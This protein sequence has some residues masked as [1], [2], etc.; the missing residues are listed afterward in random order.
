MN[1]Q[2]RRTWWR[3]LESSPLRQRVEPVLDRFAENIGAKNP[4]LIRT[5]GGGSN[6][7]FVLT[8]HLAFMKHDQGEEL[9][10]SIDMVRRGDMVVATTDICLDDG[11]YVA[12]GPGATFN[13]LE[14]ENLSKTPPNFDE[15]LA[16]FEEF[17]WLHEAVILKLANELDCGEAAGNRS[18]A[19]HSP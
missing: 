9:A 18:G 3:L 16:A 13:A 8:A 14:L 11:T 19:S 17:L 1:Q 5:I 15:W 12:D 2:I 6:D 7:A 10:I 4:D